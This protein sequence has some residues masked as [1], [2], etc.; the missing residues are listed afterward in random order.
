[1]D[2][3]ARNWELEACTSYYRSRRRQKGTERE[4]LTK[5]LHLVAAVSGLALAVLVYHPAWANVFTRP[6]GQKSLAFVTVGNPGNPG[7]SRVAGDNT[8]GH[9]AVDYTYR[10]G[11]YDVTTSQ[12]CQFLNAVARVSDPYRLYSPAMSVM[13]PGVAS[14]GIA[15]SGTEG[16]FTYSVTKN[17]D[18]PVNYVDWGDAVRFANW[19]SHGQPTGVQGPGTTETGSYTP[20]GT[21]A[22]YGPSGIA[23]TQMDLDTGW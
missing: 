3:A 22:F 8:A 11:K 4:S 15:Q 9:G 5:T 16:N 19:L 6:S 1:M 13:T 18:F 21:E 10:M 20:T 23:A 7:D 14:C 12:Y 17:P 2:M